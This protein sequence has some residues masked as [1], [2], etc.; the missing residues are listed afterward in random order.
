M[1]NFVKLR[2]TIENKTGFQ[3]EPAGQVINLNKKRF[4]KE[5]FK[6]LNK[7]INFVPT[8]TNF[9]KTMLNKEL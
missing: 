5:I 6:Q 2:R 3:S 8:Q 4:T 1:K 7:N 9:S